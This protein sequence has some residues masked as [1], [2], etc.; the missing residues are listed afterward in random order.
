MS[1]TGSSS[2][3]G[4]QEID[5]LRVDISDPLL[6]SPV[7][8]TRQDYSSAQLRNKFRHVSNALSHTRKVQYDITFAGYVE[9]RDGNFG[10]GKGSKKSPV[11]VDVTVPIET[12]TNP[13][14]ANSET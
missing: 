8:A 1:S 14:R 7:A 11:A 2:R 13:V 3:E 12:A 9:R 4:A 10:T 5:H 6:L